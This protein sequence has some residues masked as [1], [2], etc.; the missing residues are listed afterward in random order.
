[1]KLTE[2]R[3]TGKL[4]RLLTK[5][6]KKSIVPLFIL[7][8]IG[9][10]MET[11]GVS[12]IVPIVGG[13]LE[14]G[15][16][17]T[18]SFP[19]MPALCQ[20][21]VSTLL[22]LLAAI[23]LLKNLYLFAEYYVQHSAAMKVQKRIQ[24]DLAEYYF[25]Q[26]YSYFM[27][28]DSGE[29]LRTL[30]GDTSSLTDLIRHLIILCKELV[31]GVAMLAVVISISWRI[32]LILACTLSVVFLITSRLLVPYIRRQ[33]NMHRRA[34]Q[35]TNNTVVQ[36]LQGIKDIKCGEAEAFFKAEYL[37]SANI[38]AETARNERSFRETPK[39]VTETM[40]VLS[41]TGYIAILLHR[42]VPAASVLP[43][44]SAFMV[45]AIRI[46]PSVNR[47][48]NAVNG[49]SYLEGALD[50]ISG[51]YFT[52]SEQKASIEQKQK[53]DSIED[54]SLYL[55]TLLEARNIIYRYPD[56]ENN[57]LFHADL[58][59][60]VNRTTGIGGA[61]GEGKTTAADILLGLLDPQEGE[62]LL[63]G[64]PVDTKSSAYRKLFA[65]IPQQ[66][67][68]YNGSIRQN[69]AFGCREEEISDEA[70][71]DALE[72]ARI[73]DY[74]RSLPKGLDE[75]TGEAGIH[76]SGGQIQRLGIA[77]ALY[78]GAQVLVFDE[79]TSALDSDTEEALMESLDQLHGSRTII[80]IAHRKTL[81]D[82]CDECWQL[83]NGQF[84][85]V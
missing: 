35:K 3:V 34:Q 70:V 81:L 43:A 47:I 29:I 27:T 45:A 31:V 33:G 48:S 68:I 6:E 23:Y 44:V 13:I 7:I 32:T 62:I 25:M 74:V 79:A 83:E 2:F 49:I 84:R 76:L 17:A 16:V 46:L 73:A 65:Y 75:N 14:G 36:S 64:V 39:Y 38:M 37:K 50:H 26:P 71:W 77:R 82:R 63:D 60:S 55:Q 85:R 28:A 72:K 42:G 61:S 22:C 30:N 69:I 15:T 78:R 19:G 5:K 59:I 57:V 54:S 51:V 8:I 10:F 80:I 58:Q 21:P 20:V 11:V 1:M 40:T 67:F 52:A 12:L 18:F 4:L 66:I 41:M 53:E 56:R 24:D 9:A